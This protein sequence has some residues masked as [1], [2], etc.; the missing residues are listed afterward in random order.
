MALERRRQRTKGNK[1]YPQ[2]FRFDE[3]TIARIKALTAYYGHSATFVLEELVDA[4]YQRLAEED[5]GELKKA[6][7]SIR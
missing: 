3:T 1:T 2:S 6:E 5:S 7:K 4:E